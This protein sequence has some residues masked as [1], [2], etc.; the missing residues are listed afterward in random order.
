MKDI[1]FSK[2]IKMWSIYI[3]AA[4]AMK[5]L[6]YF[7]IGITTDIAKRVGGVQTGCPLRITKVWAINVYGSGKAQHVE[8]AMHKKLAVFHSHGE[9]FTFETDNAEHKA[10]MNEAMVFGHEMASGGKGKRW[11]EVSIPD[12]KAAMRD[13]QRERQ[14]RMKAA[15]EK[16]IRDA[17]VR[18]AIEGRHTL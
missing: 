3:M 12:L 9:W 5:G 17:V 2:S 10:A 7:K 15:S 11:N 6:T 1:G 14:E 18:M 4:P 16:R 13:L 8:R